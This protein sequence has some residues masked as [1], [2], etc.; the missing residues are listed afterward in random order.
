MF[1]YSKILVAIV[2]ALCAT[3]PSSMAE[4][5][6][7]NAYC[8]VEPTEP[9]VPKYRTEHG[10]KTYFFCCSECVELFEANP[11]KY[12]P[13]DTAK[14]S[15]KFSAWLFALEQAWKVVS[16]TLALWI[17][18]V[19]MIGLLILRTAKPKLRPRLGAQ[20][21]GILVTITL[22]AEAIYGHYLHRKE[23]REHEEAKLVHWVHASTFHEYGD[24][25]IPA[26][27]DV[28]P[29]LQATYYRGNDERSEQ[30]FNGGYYRTCD[31][32]LDLCNG[33]GEVR[34][35]GDEI[36]VGD[37]F[38]R[39][40]VIRAPGTPDYFW[41]PDRMA[42][43]FGSRLAEKLLGRNGEPVPDAVPMKVV[44]PML[45]WEMRYPLGPF[46]ED[47]RDGYL[48]GIVY[49]CE[50]RFGDDDVQIGSRFHYAFQ[51]ELQ[52]ADGK[53]GDQSDLWMGSTYRNRSLRIW[54]IPQHEWLSTEPIPVIDGANTTTDPKLLGIE[55][56]QLDQ[57]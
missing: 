22:G 8:L 45:E 25:P 10:G 35:Y 53:I 1:R 50:K 32:H 7:T 28:P 51:F 14:K 43:I 11:E 23:V 54:E 38:L 27:P 47:S 30:L 52:I 4:V 19:I 40:R 31:F 5:E 55:G 48:E 17:G 57:N 39:I 9:S 33:S 13:D 44:R 29:R 26:K 41:K 2:L 21:F 24:P 37:L 12:L 20:T 49:H 36:D 15:K 16:K 42:N 46:A 34:S 18:G 6:I 3:A 56:H